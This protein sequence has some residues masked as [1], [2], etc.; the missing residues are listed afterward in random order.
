MTQGTCKLTGQTG[1]FVKSHL[2][3]A[4]LTR[5]E[6][7]GAS[8]VQSGRGARPTRRWSS[9]YDR[10]LVTSEG[11][12]ILEHYDSWAIDQFRKHKLIWSSWGPMIKLS[13]LDF[14]PILGSH[15]GVRR[16]A[17]IDPKRLRLF[18]LSL[19]WRAAAT[20]LPEFD[21]VSIAPDDLEQ[22]RKMIIN[23]DPEPLDFLPAQLTQLSTIGMV[24][25]HGPISQVKEIPAFGGSRGYKVPIFRFYFD[26]LITHFHMAKA[27]D[28]P[29]VDELGPLIVGFAG[30]LVVS[31]VAYETSFQR[32]NLR[33]IMLE[34]FAKW[35]K[36]I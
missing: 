34:T 4:A 33:E 22:L 12:R 18:F 8:L 16:I 27:V 32:E 36:S 6:Y 26:G 14:Q 11:E 29:S 23:G 5:P 1:K 10:R 7:A 20:D 19:L 3:P 35:P 28:Q 31:T 21:E 9:W 25:N 24:H 30:D 15:W 17:G 13:T 2:I